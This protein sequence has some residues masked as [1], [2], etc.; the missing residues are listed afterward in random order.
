MVVTYISVS[1]QPSGVCVCSENWAGADCSVP[2]DPS[3]LVWE[4][5]LDTQLKA[6]GATMSV[7][8][9]L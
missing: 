7:M 5:L 2:L 9:A 3:T 1:S 4:T 8:C 6:V